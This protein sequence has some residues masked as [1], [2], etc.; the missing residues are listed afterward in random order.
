MQSIE[1]LKFL[2]ESQ[3]RTVAQ[4]FGTPVFVYSRERIEKSCDTALAFPN[5]F[6]LTVRYAMKANPNSTILEIMKRKGI[7]ID[8]S[9]EYEVQRALHYGFKPEHIMLTSQELA[10][11]LK[12]L[13]E[14]GVIFNACSLRQLEAFGKLFPGKEVSVRFNPGLGSGQ[15]K[16]TDVGGKTSAFGVW[17][18]DLNKVKEIAKKYDLKIFKVH[19]HIGSGSDPA[20]WKIVAQV[21]LDIAAQFPECRILNLGGGFK[22]GRME[23]EKTT[24]FQTIGKPVIELFQEFAKKN[25]TKLHMEIE[26][27][28]FMMVNNGA[29]VS[30]IDDIVSTGENGYTFVKVDAGMD[31]NTRPS[32]YAARHPLVVVPKEGTHSGKT[33]DYVFVGH[34][35]ESGD[36]FTQAE[37]GGPI[38]R[39]TGEAKLGDFI[40]MEGAGA[41]CSSMSTKNYNS[42]PETAEVLLGLDGSFQLI[43]KRQNL[44]QIFQNEVPV[45][46]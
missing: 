9:S 7:Q 36:L 13:V 12:E 16:K 46:L 20:V 26:P 27:G 4:Q 39:T 45:S 18:E 44:E 17:H 40:V 31:V 43:R 42:F 32:L 28:S 1:K 5:A 29:I 38:T 41:Y 22:V 8:A 11:G 6:G 24:D 30:T 14:K 10:K 23:D 19:T 21:S 25:G 3:V 15:T 37:G 2:T 33:E 34:C 35:C